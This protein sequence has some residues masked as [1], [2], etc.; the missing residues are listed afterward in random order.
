MRLRDFAF[1]TIAAF[2]ILGRSL[3]A[4]ADK[5]G[6]AAAVNPDAFS[7][8]AGTPKTQLNIGKS[9]FYNERINTTGSGLVQVLL[10]D[11]STFT[12]GPGSDLVIDR[13][14]Y[15]PNKKTG[16]VVASLSKGMMRRHWA[17]EWCNPS[18]HLRL[19]RHPRLR[20]RPSIMGLADSAPRT[21]KPPLVIGRARTQIGCPLRE[22][23]LYLPFP[24]RSFQRRLPSAKIGPSGSSPRAEVGLMR[25]PKNHMWAE[26]CGLIKQAEQLHRQFFEP[27]GGARTA[28]WEPPVDVFET[29]RQLWIIAA[30]PGVTPEEMRVEF[31]GETLVI[32]GTRP[33]PCKGRN[34][35]ILRLEIP[36]GRFERRITLSARLRLAERELSNGCLVLTFAKPA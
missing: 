20:R 17:R 13:F 7:S 5:V 25:D 11:G 9:I 31:Q 28:R 3:P 24:P 26:A 6:V 15:D 30:L 34:A 14:V 35:N 33:L 12:V 27:C 32:A 36:Y 18:C 2:A 23:A 16:Q 4:T 10:V 29:E 22:P 1:A 21:G 19:R 8:L